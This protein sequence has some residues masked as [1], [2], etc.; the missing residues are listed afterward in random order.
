MSGWWGGSETEAW[1]ILTPPLDLP[2]RLT[3]VRTR[4]AAFELMLSLHPEEREA[5][6]CLDIER[7][8][9]RGRENGRSGGPT[10][11]RYPASLPF[12]SMVRSSSGMGAGTT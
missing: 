12:L 10:Q 6:F 3:P 7:M 9:C 2:P 11:D 1:Q 8:G 5:G 4:Q